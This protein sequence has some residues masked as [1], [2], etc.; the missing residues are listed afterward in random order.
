MP[1]VACQ[2]PMNQPENAKNSMTGETG[3][4]DELRK[5][6]SNPKKRPE[7][8]PW[9]KNGIFQNSQKIPTNIP[10]YRVG[11]VLIS[12]GIYRKVSGS[13]G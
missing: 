9:S 12:N 10:Q 2:I 13:E 8:F 5:I 6:F 3:S 1:P 4:R 7:E 11:E